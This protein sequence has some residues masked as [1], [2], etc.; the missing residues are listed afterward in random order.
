[1]AKRQ[2]L[3]YVSIS[4]FI[5][6][7]QPDELIPFYCKAK[8]GFWSS[9]IEGQIGTGAQALCCGCSVVSGNAGTLTCFHHYASRESGRLA[10]GMKAEA[11]DARSGSLGIR[12]GGCAPYQ[13]HMVREVSRRCCSQ[14]LPRAAEYSGLRSARRRAQ[15][16]A[17]INAK[18]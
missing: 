9:R 17:V 4:E 3:I 1:M 16:I 8:I 13:Q 10:V 6:S 18:M 14:A 5:D 7:L 11:M 12:T 2:R 15:L